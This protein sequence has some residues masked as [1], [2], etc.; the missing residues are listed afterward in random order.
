MADVSR[1]PKEIKMITTREIDV[2]RKR[3]NLKH[4]QVTTKTVDASI[5]IEPPKEPIKKRGISTTSLP[6]VADIMEKKRRDDIMA[7]V[8]KA[9]KKASVSKIMAQTVEQGKTTIEALATTLKPDKKPMKEMTAEK[10]KAAMK[11]RM[12]KVRA[13]KKKKK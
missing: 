5:R 7:E 2:Y 11:E 6:D 13:A 8:K 12:A 4:R 9:K 3:A 1:P 10:K